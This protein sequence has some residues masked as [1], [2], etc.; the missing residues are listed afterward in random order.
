ML[1]RNEASENMRHFSYLY[2]AT[3]ATSTFQ[4]CLAVKVV[5]SHIHQ[6]V[7]STRLAISATI[8]PPNQ[9]IWMRRVMREFSRQGNGSHY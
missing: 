3:I 4:E 1:T 6:D 2:M 7:T 9:P 8:E 5:A